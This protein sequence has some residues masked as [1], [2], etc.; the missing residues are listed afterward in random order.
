MPSLCYDFDRLGE[1]AD[2]L[3]VD[4]PRCREHLLPARS[5]NLSSSAAL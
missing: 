5:L 1:R 3:A 4:G 2:G